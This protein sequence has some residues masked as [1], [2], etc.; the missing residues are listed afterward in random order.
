MKKTPYYVLLLCVFSLISLQAGEKIKLTILH[1]N[2]THSQIEPTEKSS[3]RTSDMGGYARR[4]GVIQ[5]IR[6]QEKNVLLFDAGDFSQ[7]TPYFNFFNGR[8]EVDGFNRMQYDAITIGNHEFDN[9][10]DTLAV[11]LKQAQFTIISSNYNINNTPLKTLVKPYFI[12][13]RFGLKIGIMALNVQPKSL[14]FEKNY[15]GLLYND[16]VAKAI[17]L[18]EYL[19][20]KQHCD[21]IVCLSHLGSDAQSVDVNDY[22]IAKATRYIDIIIGGH[23]HTLLENASTKNADGRSVVIAQVAKSGW[24]MGRIDLE[25]EKK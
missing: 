17:Q 6:S 1:T 20:K 21:L 24:F 13:K 16:P 2:D 7:G 22:T 10:M 23:S 12:L 14:I 18:S 8:L 5:K 4:M 19:K 11:I 3:L 25:M 9:G 15:R